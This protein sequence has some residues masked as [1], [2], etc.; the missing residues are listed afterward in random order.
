MLSAFPLAPTSLPSLST[1]QKRT[2][3]AEEVQPKKHSKAQPVESSSE[4]ES[5]E[6]EVAQESGSEE[7]SDAAAEEESEEEEEEEEKVCAC[8]CSD[9]LL[10]RVSF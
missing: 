3:V 4:E 6:E 2:N 1:A 10:S 8:P 9:Q 5:E 7:E